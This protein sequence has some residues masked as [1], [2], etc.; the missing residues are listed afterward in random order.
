VLRLPRWSPLQIAGYLLVLVVV[1]PLL[2][3]GGARVIY[4]LQYADV[5]FL[6]YPSHAPVAPS[7]IAIQMALPNPHDPVPHPPG[8]HPFGPA[9][10]PHHWIPINASGFRGEDIHA[11]KEAARR[12]VCLGGS[13]TFSAEC[14]VGTSYPEVL[15]QLWR[16]DLGED[17]V[18]VFNMGMLGYSTREIAPL[19]RDRLVGQGVDLVTVCSAYNNLQGLGL[20]DLRPGIA[21]WHRRT[22]WG[23][24]LLYTVM[25]NGARA[26]AVLDRPWDVMEADYRDELEAM[27][28]LATA[29][30]QR[31]LFVLQPLADPA[32]VDQA[33]VL[34]R[35]DETVKD[36]QGV[37]EGYLR[38]VDWHARLCEVM[39]E[40]ADSHG[41]PWVDPRP[42]VVEH[43]DSG[44]HFHVFLHLTPEG[45]S[46]MAE[47]IHRQVEERYGGLDGLLAGSGH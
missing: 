31:L 20:L 15:E 46:M 30:E 8:M 29:E 25:F 9:D 28:A 2:A 47:E 19:M 1:V 42:A 16:G 22:L 24:S 13:C 37:W 14:P 23:R 12:V 4:A 45:S 38:S 41:V 35:L 21:P 39:A 27:I 18:E 32:R 43:P 17:S 3:E 36:F 11:P 5:N 40:V 44:E 34:H 26:R 10:D 6:R 7:V 33:E